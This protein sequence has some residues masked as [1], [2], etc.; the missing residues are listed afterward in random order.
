VK[1]SLFLIISAFSFYHIQ[2]QTLPFTFG[3]IKEFKTINNPIGLL[4]GDFNGDKIEDFA[5][6]GAKRVRFYYQM[7]DSLGFSTRTFTPANSVI[8]VASAKVNGD[9]LTDFVCIGGKPLSLQVYI[10]K[11]KSEPYLILNREIQGAFDKILMGDINSDSKNDIIL[12]GRKELGLMVF[13]GKGNGMFYSPLTLF[14]GDS[15]SELY[16]KDVNNDGVNDILGLQWI[17][18]KVKLYTGYASS[19]F[20]EPSEISLASEGSLMKCDYLN[21]DDNL[22]FMIYFPNEKECATF[23]GNGLGNFT[24]HQIIKIPHVLSNALI[25]KTNDDYLQDILLLSQDDR[26]LDIHLQDQNGLF[27]DGIEYY[28]TDSP[29]DILHFAHQRTQLQDI[30][31][32]D[33]VNSFLKIMYNS[34]IDQPRGE[35]REYGLG[36]SP[37]EVHAIDLNDDGWNDVI[38]SNKGSKSYSIFLNDKKGRYFGQWYVPTSYMLK[39]FR[40]ASGKTSPKI[41]F[42]TE[43]GVSALHALELDLSNYTYIES[44]IITQDVPEII[45]VNVRSTRGEKLI[46]SMGTDPENNQTRLTEIK[47]LNGNTAMEH[48]INFDITDRIIYTSNVY[49]TKENRKRI[50]CTAFYEKNE[51]LYSILTDS[52]WNIIEKKIRSTLQKEIPTSVFMWSSDL[53]RDGQPDC[54]VFRKDSL[55]GLFIYQGGDHNHTSGPIYVIEDIDMES[56]KDL[57]IADIDKNGD[58]DIVVQNRLRRSLDAYVGN[59]TGRF[60]SMV[61]LAGTAR[62]G[63]FDISDVDNDGYPEVI[64]TDSLKGTLNILP[65]RER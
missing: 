47:W 7:K 46:L 52:N 39:S 42:S 9:D 64:M 23:M 57:K 30:V 16:L 34:S 14:Q 51:N 31:I 10:M 3:L 2:G 45:D 33:S 44:K 54:I 6:Y 40:A 53:N 12:Y 29:V 24:Q 17:D 25:T 41:I 8:Y 27:T 48:V 38:V 4:Q 22:D 15:F 37:S 35:I 18:N 55:T 21:S 36:V 63:G 49:Y 20:S 61:N 11:K 50:W 56:P 1:Y 60:W 28:T 59:G 58:P 13:R 32:M 43:K 65:I 19:T 5:V 62:W 26:T